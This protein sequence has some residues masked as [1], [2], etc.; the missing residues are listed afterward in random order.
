MA[1]NSFYATKNTIGKCSNTT[2]KCVDKI[3]TSMQYYLSRS[4]QS[5]TQQGFVTQGTY[6]AYKC[7]SFY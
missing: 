4:N 5:Y 1:Q 6:F 3:Y 2:N 7:R